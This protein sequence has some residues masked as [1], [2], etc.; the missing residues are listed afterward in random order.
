MGSEDFASFL[1]EEQ[2][3]RRG[4]H[5]GSSPFL[6]FYFYKNTFI[7]TRFISINKMTGDWRL[8]IYGHIATSP[9]WRFF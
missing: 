1:E 8:N 4:G 6:H 5:L 2:E 9:H 7:S 3:R